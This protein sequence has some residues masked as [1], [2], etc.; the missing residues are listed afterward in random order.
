MTKGL[1]QNIINFFKHKFFTLLFFLIYVGCNKDQSITENDIESLDDIQSEED[2]EFDT[3][4]IF[5]PYE[6]FLDDWSWERSKQ[7]ENFIVFWEPGFGKDPNDES[8]PVD[9][10]FDVDLLLDKLDYYYQVHRNELSFFDINNTLL[11]QY[12]IMVFV[13]YSL[14]YGAFG[15]GYE[16]TIG[17]FWID[18]N[19]LNPIRTAVAHELGHAFQYQVRCDLGTSGYRWGFG[20]NGSGGNTYWESTAQWQAF[21]CEP[22]YISD[23]VYGYVAETHN[24]FLDEIHRY[25]SYWMHYYWSSIHSKE[26]ISR[27][28]RETIENEDPA[29]TYMR[30]TDTNTQNFFLQLFEGSRKFVTW[31]IG[32]IKERMKDFIGIH[33]IGL[34]LIDGKYVIDP[35]F[36]PETTGYNVIEL[37]IPDSNNLKIEFQGLIN[38]NYFTIEEQESISGWNIGVVSI[39]EN[40]NRFYGETSSINGHSPYTFN[41]DIPESSER[42]WLVISPAPKRY[43][44]HEWDEDQ[45]NDIQW[46]YSLSIDENIQI[47][48]LVD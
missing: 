37:S 45:D 25:E 24:H 43:F 23:G 13:H 26:I 7:S 5:I 16:D 34:E 4:K 48:N 40:G 12:K 31:D 35:N 15:A 22:E 32:E 18:P 42:L 9:F 3:S 14:D 2:S 46:P 36:A 41:Q 8:V 30:I 38:D 39:L 11:N 1:N 33:R 19:S 10:R 44:K 29:E 6:D 21:Q 27:I 47:L 28:W 20:E 17:A